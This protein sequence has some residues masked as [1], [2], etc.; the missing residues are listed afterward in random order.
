MNDLKKLFKENKY[1]LIPYILLVVFSIILLLSFSKTELHIASN[2][3]NN[4]FFDVFFKYATNLGNG[5]AIAIL[6]IVLLMLRYRFAFAF[7]TGSLIASLIVNIFKKLFFHD[8]Y[9]PLKYFE[10]YSTYK[11]HLVEG[12]NMHLLQSFPSGHSATAFNVF[13]T[14]AILVKSNTL[15][16]TFLIMA[17][18][19]AYSRV[20]LSQHFL[21]DITVGSFIGTSCIIFSFIWFSNMKSS[22]LNGS[23]IHRK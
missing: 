7:L 5:W 11:L 21:I 14:L 4:A 9:R 15:K 22:W 3:A 2:K 1:F 10:Q 23:L 12:V 16:F 19:V 13:F 20:Y 8:V 18:L 6:F 17:L